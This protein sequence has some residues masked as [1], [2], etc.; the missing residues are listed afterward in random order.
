MP[1]DANRY[2][3]D[4]HANIHPEAKQHQGEHSNVPHP[5]PED[6][7][8]HKAFPDTGWR[9]TPKIPSQDGGDGEQDFMNKP[10]YS[11]KSE[12]DIFKVKYRTSVLVSA[13]YH[14]TRLTCLQRV[15]VWERSFRDTR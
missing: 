9:G 5:P 10:P 12:N 6:N 3:G 4:V 15:L 11:W 1:Q 7:Q 14:A 2:D 13:H 8:E